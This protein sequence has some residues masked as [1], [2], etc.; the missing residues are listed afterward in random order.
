MAVELSRLNTFEGGAPGTNITAANSGGTS[1]DPFS[2]VFYNNA[3]VGSTGNAAIAYSA[4]AAVL[5][6]RGCQFAAS[7]TTASYLR[8][9]FS[10]AGPYAFASVRV[11]AFPANPAATVP[12]LELRSASLAGGFLTLRTDGTVRV[13]NRANTSIAAS[14][15]PALVVGN[16]YTFELAIK[17]GTTTTDGYLGMRIYNAD[18]TIFHEWSST[19]VDAG[20][21]PIAQARIDAPLTSSAWSNLDIDNAQARLASLASDWIGHY[22][23]VTP[24]NAVASVTAGVAIIDASGTTGG[25]SLDYAIAQISGAST[26]PATAIA[27]NIWW[28]H[29]HATE[30]SVWRVTVTDTATALTDTVDV[31][32]PHIPIASPLMPTL[33]YFDGTTIQTV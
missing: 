15:S 26:G 27:E 4:T 17:P 25:A 33:R 18:G 11:K 9:D 28:V 10:G 31:T 20:V 3:S 8:W 16:S 21:D 30:D 23:P 6:A 5:G 32:V 7:G 14:A 19:A 29:Q 24:P 2:F 13:N 22:N 12:L 1:G